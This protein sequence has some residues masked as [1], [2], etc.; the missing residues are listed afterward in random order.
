LL[1][2]QYVFLFQGFDDNGPVSIAGTL[3]ADGNGNITSGQ[4]DSNRLLLANQAS[5][6]VVGAT[7]T[8]GTYSIG[9]DGRG[10]MELSFSNPQTGVNLRTDYNLVLYSNGNV[11]FVEN[12]TLNSSAPNGDSLHTHGEGTLKY[13]TNT[14]SSSGAT[15]SVSGASFSGNYAFEF[16]GQD[17][18]GKPVV[19]AGTVNADGTGG[20]LTP[21]AGGVNSDFNDNGSFSSQSISGNFS[22]SSTFNRGAVRMIF[23]V[24][25]KSSLTLTF[26]CYFASPT[27]IYFV[28]ID[29]STTT[30]ATVYYL[31][32]GEMIGQE[33]GYQFQPAAATSVATGT[34][35]SGNNTSVLAGLL[36]SAS[37]GA[38]SLS[39]DENNGGT[40]A[41]PS[42]TGT[43]AVGSNGRVAFTWAGTAT[44]RVAVAYLT[45]PGQGFLLGYDA[46]ATGG[47]LEQQTGSPFSLSSFQGSY[48]VGTATPEDKL[49]PNLVGQ[50]VGLYTPVPATLSLN[51]MI[52][53]ID[54]SGTPHT[55]QALG[56][57][58]NTLASNGRGTIGANP[59]NGFPTNLVFYMVSP[60]TVRAIP[61]DSNPTNVHPE[62]ILLDH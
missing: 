47:L 32:S 10:T 18:S 58:V 12:N 54:P 42:L 21:G 27:D 51:G 38:A 43:Y 5:S 30:S 53:E 33:A 50:V 13:V 26:D 61:S 2:G 11:R 9:N 48:A 41:A 1:S 22:V 16:T 7:L 4:E 8:A 31:L 52:D 34:G 45:G 23:Q 28:E 57:T 56:A 37:S 59:L 62:V 29:N 35:V 40:L 15:S 19:L 25:G 60:G 39:Y 44:P 3:V 17:L 24:P 6:V 14:S 49:V 36:T 20:N 55:S 46:A